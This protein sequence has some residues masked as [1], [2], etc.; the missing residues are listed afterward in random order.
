LALDR[1]HFPLPRDQ[2]QQLQEVLHT[3]MRPAS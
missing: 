2:R 1:L 3:K